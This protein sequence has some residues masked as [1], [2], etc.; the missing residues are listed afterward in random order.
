[1]KLNFC[2]LFN[3]AYLS[4]GIVLYESL[5]KAEPNAHLYIFAFDDACAEVLQKLK[6][7]QA[8][9]VTLKEFENDKLL[10][11]KSTRTSQEYCWTCASSTILFCFQNFNL[12]NCTYIDADMYFYASPQVLLD[13]MPDGCSVLITEHRYTP[14]YDQSKTSGKYCVQ[15]M[16][17]K[18]NEDGLMVLNWWVDACLDWCFA[19][20]EDGKFGDQK[21]LD[22]WTTQFKGI[23]WELQHIGGG[24][25]PWNIQQY[26]FV[27]KDGSLYLNEL[28]STKNY[29]LVFYH[30]HGLQFYR[31]FGSRLLDSYELQKKQIA[32]IY[33]PYIQN[34][35]DAKQRILQID[36]SVKV[37]HQSD[38]VAFIKK[39]IELMK[40]KIT[41]ILS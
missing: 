41:K 31:F 11:V 8:T 19:R 22:N 38:E 33:K 3:A 32:Q 23:V 26:N 20:V 7:A 2:T 36:K 24:V 16:Y 5:V 40:V 35:S 15:F 27:K 10:K 37:L 28:E 18:N 29:P 25:A 34:L 39:A 17:F 4:R 12:E 9:I 21:Y 14:Q 1:M 13:E 6:L 30:F